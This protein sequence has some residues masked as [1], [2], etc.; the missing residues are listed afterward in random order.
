ML[1]LNFER[2]NSKIWGGGGRWI[3]LHLILVIYNFFLLA[4]MENWK[5]YGGYGPPKLQRSSAP[6]SGYK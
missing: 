4:L 6:A 5:S 3:N 1:I 2:V